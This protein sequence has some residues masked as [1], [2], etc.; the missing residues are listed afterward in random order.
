MTS[1]MEVKFLQCAAQESSSLLRSRW[2]CK[3]FLKM[4]QNQ[5]KLVTYFEV[6]HEALKCS[7]MT[8][9]R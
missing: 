1:E 8:V 3:V 4:L 9:Y 5:S 6:E 2:Y 7:L